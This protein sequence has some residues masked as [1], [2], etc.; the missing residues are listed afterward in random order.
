VSRKP[1]KYK[2]K[3]V[4]IEAMEFSKIDE[5]RGDLDQAIRIKNWA[6]KN[7]ILPEFSST[8]NACP[9]INIKT[10]EGTHLASPGDFIIKG[11]IG[12]F[13]PCKPEVF[14]QKYEVIHE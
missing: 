4:V 5:T 8:S 7:I 11:L 3:P 6:G 13:Y 2:T 10:L 14:H 9:W 1:L 12:E